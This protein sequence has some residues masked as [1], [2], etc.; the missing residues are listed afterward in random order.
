MT[1]KQLAEDIGVSKVAVNKRIE[2]LGLKD[3][4]E[5]QGN[6]FLISEAVADK[7]RESFT[8]R[9]RTEHKPAENESV[10]Q[11]LSDQLKQKDEQI[12]SLMRQL[13]LLQNQNSDL[14]KMQRESHYLLAKSMGADESEPIESPESKEEVVKEE[15]TRRPEQKKGFFRRLF[16]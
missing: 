4:L 12:A 16:G 15:P 11:V 9:S 6:K 1:I 14:L 5:K 7:V 2:E 10:I 3:Q 13:E 8:D